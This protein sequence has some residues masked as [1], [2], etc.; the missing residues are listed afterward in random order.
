MLRTLYSLGWLL[1][2]PLALIYLLYR[3]I[4][5]PAYRRHWLERFGFSQ[6]AAAGRRPIWIHA[7]SVGETAAAVPLVRK[8][9]ERYPGV[10]LLLTHT[11]P[12]GREAGKALLHDLAPRLHQCY[13]PYDV[14]SFVARFLAAQQPL[15]GLVMETEVWP[16]LMHAAAARGVPTAAV[17]ARLSEKSL[18]RGLEYR[19][20]IRPAVEAFDIIVAQSAGDSQRLAQLARPA[21]A[22]AGNLKFDQPVAGDA[23][24]VGRQWRRRLG[25]RPVVLAASTRD[26]EEALLLESWRKCALGG[27]RRVPGSGAQDG[28]ED[29]TQ[30]DEP[31]P[32]LI[33]VPRHPNRFETVAALIAAALPRERL[34]RRRALDQAVTDTGTGTGSGTGSG[35]G[36]CGVLLGDSMGEMQRWY[37][38]AD[39]VIMGGSLLPFGSQNLIE[40]NA[41]GCPVVL[42]PSVFNFE[43]A[44]AES[45]AAGAA[46][47]VT[48]SDAAVA[49]ALRIAADP[50]RRDTMSAAALG[51]AQAHRGATERTLA[52][53]APMLQAC[54]GPAPPAQ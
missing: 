50:L 30:D 24:E 39:V 22:V 15:C 33:V 2:I 28:G 32:L 40:A 23:R 37:A 10:R 31:P 51:F 34:L 41:L 6:H 43:Q 8:L 3:S 12:T 17:N 16:N 13:L 52:A 21:D 54:L 47:Q 53:L 48:D 27:G 42:G 26:G 7:V 49:T 35:L 18:S 46:V 1:A 29:G 19:G 9:A 4:R 20:L 25:A 5:Q 38:C 44:A 36:G 45:I 14:P 11:T